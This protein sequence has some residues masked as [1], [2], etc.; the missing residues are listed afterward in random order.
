MRNMKATPGNNE[1]IFLVKDL[2]R[3]IEQ[4]NI[5]RLIVQY[6]KKIAKDNILRKKNEQRY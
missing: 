6:S 4:R 1:N 2:S 3:I 5:G